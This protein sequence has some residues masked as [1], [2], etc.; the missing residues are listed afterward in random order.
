[1]RSILGRVVG[2]A[3]VTAGLATFSLPPGPAAAAAVGTARPIAI[4]VDSAGTS[5]VGYASGGA[6]S[7]VSSSGKRLAAIP[8]D[9]DGPVVGL[10]IDGADDLWVAYD[11]AVTTMTIDGDVIRRFER[12]SA[13]ACDTGATN[14]P[15][16]YGGLALSGTSV[17][18]VSRCSATL[19]V[20]A[21]ASGAEQAVV[22]L[23]GGYR[24]RGL[25][26]L[27]A[28]G[29]DPARLFVATPGNRSLLTYAAATV[30]S[31]STPIKR[32]YVTSPGRGRR[33]VPAGVAVDSG[34]RLAVSDV[35]NH[36]IY[37]YDTD[38]A[39]SRY[40][41]LGH[42][43]AASDA[44]GY[45]N[46]P[47]ALAQYPQDRGGLSGNLFI[48]DTRNGR[49]QRW[50][51]GG[52]Y[53]FWVRS[54][55]DPVVGGPT[56]PSDPT[57]P[58][59]GPSGA[60]PTIDAAEDGA[61]LICT[62]GT[63]TGDPASYTFTWLRDGVLRPGVSG[64]SYVLG[65]A[66]EGT[67]ISCRVTTTTVT[68]S[69]TAPSAPWYAGTPAAPVS[70]SAPTILGTPARDNT[71]LCDTGGWTGLPT[72][73]FSFVW[74]R[75]SVQVS[76]A[77]THRV[78]AADLGA[79]LTCTVIATNQAG[80]ASAT[81]AA[82]VPAGVGTDPDPG[83]DPTGPC[84]G[85]PR[86]VIAAGAARIRNPRVTLRIVPPTGAT[87][88]E[89]SNGPTFVDTTPVT[90]T[91]SC[92]TPWRLLAPASDATAAHVY[93]R[94]VGGPSDGGVVSDTIAF[95]RTGPRITRAVV[96]FS[97]KAWRLRVTAKDPSGLRTIQYGVTR[98]RGLRQVK[99]GRQVRVK[100]PHVAKWVRV[101]DA[102]GNR[103]T[104]YRVR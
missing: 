28:R 63:G 35:A 44:Q 32:T 67:E 90:L 62:A 31:S 96:R 45:L 85:T 33:P 98:K 97:R 74:L 34:G 25:A 18:V 64:S 66:D 58:G 101:V 38:R 79:S 16:S 95:D 50:D 87:G 73:Q 1:M 22:A 7:R 100:A 59:G 52:G 15:A 36:A 29:G 42:P 51:S 8:L 103:S 41:V 3:L 12:P 55:A 89:V 78:V 76:G 2:L 71:L 30:S 88:V 4:A 77:P 57:D 80:S 6:L 17:Y 19:E 56:D 69:S 21:K 61:S 40:R 10:A 14:S 84:L 26:W 43:S 91:S 9:E 49:V 37:L 68:G 5:Y 39:Y 53:T 27:R 92:T 70:T 11:D 23:P 48:A 13:V 83:T 102:F 82:V 20:Y 86:V 47:S 93:V 81:S 65:D 72:P 99:A 46:P 104:W 75:D 94:W 54:L 24:G 60:V